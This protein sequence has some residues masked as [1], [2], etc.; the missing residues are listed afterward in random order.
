MVLVLDNA[1]SILDPQGSS[2]QEIYAVVE[3]LSQFGNICLCLTSRISTIPPAC[4]T[5]DV[6][7]LS[8]EAARNTFY[9]IYKNRRQP[10]LVDSILEQLDF[11]P[12]S[13]TL[14]A[15]VSHHSKW[16]TNRLNREWERQRTAVLRTRHNAS[17]ATTIELSLASPMFQELG[18]DGRELLGVVAF[19][20]QGIDENNLDWLFP[21]L[22][23]L[24]SI[25]DDFCTLSLTYRSGSFI[26][27]LAPLRDHLRPKDPTSS[28]LLCA[29]K[30]HYF[31]RL[32]VSIEPDKP[33]FE[34]A[35]WITSEDA[36]V[37]HM[38]DVFTSIDTNS[39]GV[40][41]ACSNFMKH[42][43][44]HKPRLVTLGPKIEELPNDHRS[45]PECLDKLSWLFESIGNYTESKRILLQN[46]KLR[47]E[48][49]D[50]FEVAQT[51]NS[52]SE[53]NR[54][55]GLHKEGI[56]LVKEA[57]EIYERLNCIP[58]QAQS[59]KRLAR[60]L[61]GDKQLDAAEEA[62]SKAIGLLSGDTGDQYEACGCYHILGR[63]CH[64]RGEIGNAI[65]HFEAAL[66]IASS[67][68]WHN[69]LCL[70]HRS[71]A[72]LF[73]DENRFDDAHAHIERAKSH[74][75]NDPYH[76]GHAM[77]LQAGFWYQRGMLEEAKSEALRAIDVY[78]KIGAAEDV[79]DC[80]ALLRKI[81]GVTSSALDSNGELLEMVPFPMPVI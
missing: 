35:Q 76:L 39:V 4:D 78:E 20:P 41:D 63:I 21:A 67:F 62:A 18:P 52:I 79:K 40:W 45:K 25:F 65:N 49:G 34:E 33:G 69:P 59:W 7:T 43:Y 73:F 58:G 24:P 71:L 36:N 61:S 26:T 3:E 53:A 72:Q 37:E 14:L 6:P 29:T 46:L 77:E 74:A 51:L 19:F 48:R 11:H 9:R 42:L 8:M 70:N 1:E 28:P 64:L 5:L 15:T 81:E 22:P 75:T 16:D 55:L 23:N 30:D 27:M 2:A 10:D 68:K 56:Q 57:L 50:D 66:G 12:L 54:V 47:R 44:W 38:L 13:I 80:R 60:L 31:R 17:L 32:S